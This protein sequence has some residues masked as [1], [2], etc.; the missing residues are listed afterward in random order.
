MSAKEI[1]ETVAKKAE[2]PAAEINIL[3][4][5][6][7]L[8]YEKALESG[9]QLQED[10]VKLGK[11]VLARIGAPE[12]IQAR[13]DTVSATLFPYIRKGLKDYVETCSIGVMF[14][15][16]LGA[17]T[18]DFA[19]KSLAIYQAPSIPEAQHRAQNVIEEALA[20]GR[21]NIRTLLQTNLRIANRLGELVQSNPVKDL[22]TA[23][24]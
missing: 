15:N 4:H 12:A 16:Q 3:V 10:S 1:K 19:G 2:A 14:A 17:Q 20:I 18:L 22:C 9:V 11:H 6:A 7:M 21:E 24:A 5:E 23:A 8:G 13:L